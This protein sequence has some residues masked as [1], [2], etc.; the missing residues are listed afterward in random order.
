MESYNDETEEP[1]SDEEL[2]PR[3]QVIIN[4]TEI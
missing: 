4:L 3:I 1:D 2:D